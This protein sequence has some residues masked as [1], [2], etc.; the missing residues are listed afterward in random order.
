MTSALISSELLSSARS[1][2]TASKR[3]G[4]SVSVL[5]SWIGGTSSPASP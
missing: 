3:G 4:S 2:G 5:M 1:A